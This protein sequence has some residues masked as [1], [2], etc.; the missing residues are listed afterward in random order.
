MG[1]AD[2]RVEAAPSAPEP[3]ERRLRGIPAPVLYAICIV[4][5]VIIAWRGPAFVQSMQPQHPIRTGVYT[6]EG[7]CDA[8]VANL[9]VFSAAMADGSSLPAEDLTCPATGKPYVVE[10]S[11]DGTVV[12]CPNPEEHG[13]S[14]LSV[15]GGA[16]IPEAT[17]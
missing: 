6:T 14:S 4:C 2:A 3:E 8:C 16:Q 17:R 13:L 12:S 15:G 11:S 5:L 7:Q 10:D 1:A 9:W